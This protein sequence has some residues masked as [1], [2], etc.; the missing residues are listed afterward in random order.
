MAD[1]MD[2]G[3]QL[4]VIDPNFSITASK[5]TKWIPL[6]PGSDAAFGLSVLNVLLTESLYD[7]TFVASNTT[8]PFLVRQDNGLFLRASDN[9]TILV[10]DPVS[11]SALPADQVGQPALTGT[12]SVNGVTVQPAFELLARRVSRWTPE[13]A[14]N[15]TQVEPADVR[16]FARTYAATKRSFIFPSMGVDRWYNADLVGRTVGVMAALTHNFGQSGAAIGCAGGASMF[17]MVDHTAPTGTTGPSLPIMAAYD[18]IE[19]GRTQLLVPLDPANPSAGLAAEPAEVDWPIKAIWFTKSNAVS[20]VQQSRRFIDLL[21]D[22]SKLELVVVSDSLPTDTVRYA[23]IVLPTTHWFENNDVVGT[24]SHPY[25][26]RLEKALEGPFETKSDYQAIGLVATKLG[27]GQYYSRS[28]EELAN[29]IAQASTAA[30]GPQGPELYT[31]YL[32]SGAV[33]LTT[34]SIYIG[35]TSN[36]YHTPT[37]RLEPYSESVLVNYP[38]NGRIPITQGVDSLPY[39]EAPVQAWHTNPLTAK[40]PLVYMQEHSRWRV[41][42]TYFD[43][44]WLREVNPYPYVDLSRHDAQARGI[45]AGDQVEIFNDYGNTIAVARVSGKMRPG[46]VNLPKGW[47]RFQTKNDTGFSDPTNNW[48]NQRTMNGSYF[49]NLVE[50]RKVEV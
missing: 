43:Q 5:A 26:L 25:M 28:E 7:Q 19:H 49:D 42:S 17:L 41:H 9:T 36:K 34:M 29:A 33:K 13:Y 11:S 40:Y 10:W 47:Q 27:Y 1:A 45:S 16:W 12:Y 35:N 32:Q 22:E 21:K 48:V 15:I 18:A 4:V 30:V 50:V 44:P 38:S 14:K 37:G 2:R 23:D 8:L 20:N 46:M 24:I 39:W 6:R 3:A 31:E